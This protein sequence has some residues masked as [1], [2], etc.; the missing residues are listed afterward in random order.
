M[1]A[2]VI[3]QTLLL[4]LAIACIIALLI[5]CPSR[6]GM[7]RTIRLYASD[8]EAANEL[9]DRRRAERKNSVVEV[10]S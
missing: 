1:D 10:R 9:I 8:H 7:W 3:L 5:L 6:A 2:I 4:F